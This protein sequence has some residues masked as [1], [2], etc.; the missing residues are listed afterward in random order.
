MGMDDFFK[1]LVAQMTNQ[2]MTDP[3]S[4]T[5]FIA[6][7]AQFSSLQGMKTLQ[8]YQL[9]SYAVSYV[10]KHVTIAQVNQQTGELETIA[11]KVESVTFYDG[12]PQVI[13]NGTG[14]ELHTVM[15]VGVAPG[16]R[17]PEEGNGIK[18]PQSYTEALLLY[19]G[20]LVTLT[21]TGEN[22]EEQELTGVVE[23]V[24]QRDSAFFV[25]IDDKEYLASAKTIK[26]I[27]EAP[28]QE[29]ENSEL[30]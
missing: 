5:E 17:T 14:Y 1:L 3:Q 9:S 10:G 12:R 2:D 23:T 21:Y 25:V 20:K 24:R 11:G 29:P 15:E 8:E 30:D 4:N 22:D 19:K 16:D 13:V 26:D 28:A 27:Q 7:M 6:Q 18:Q